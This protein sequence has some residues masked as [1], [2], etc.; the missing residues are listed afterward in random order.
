MG[1]AYGSL[2]Q[3]KEAEKFYRKAIEIEPNFFKPYSNLS[4]ALK[5]QGK[6][7]EAIEVANKALKLQPSSAEVYNNLG[8]LFQELG[9]WARQ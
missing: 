8:I 4:L 5:D 2:N 9:S 7:E 1:I 3:I 6:L